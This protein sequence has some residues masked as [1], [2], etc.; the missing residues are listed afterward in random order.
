MLFKNHPTDKFAV[1][2]RDPANRGSWTITSNYDTPE[3]GAGAQEAFRN[4]VKTEAY[5]VNLR[6][7]IETV[8]DFVLSQVQHSVAKQESA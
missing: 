6:L 7:L 2:F 1:I 3:K 4:N 8:P 5:A